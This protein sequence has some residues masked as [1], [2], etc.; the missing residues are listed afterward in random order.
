MGAGLAAAGLGTGGGRMADPTW[1]T[2]GETRNLARA[3]PIVASIA[4]CI[5]YVMFTYL[6]GKATRK[7]V[8]TAVIYF[9]SVASS[10]DT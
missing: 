9:F 7:P 3:A 2:G 4:C 5:L 6:V 1:G 10:L 8:A